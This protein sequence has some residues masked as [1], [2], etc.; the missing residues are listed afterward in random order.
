[1][2]SKST[3]PIQEDRYEGQHTVPDFD[4]FLHSALGG[5]EDVNIAA[6][7]GND[8]IF[9]NN[10]MYYPGSQFTNMSSF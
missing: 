2:R 10:D 6:I 5:T 1:M 7:D 9:G 3:P 4:D 8:N